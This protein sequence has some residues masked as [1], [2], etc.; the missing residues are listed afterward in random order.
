MKT[1]KPL[2]IAL[3]LTGIVTLNGCSTVG[4][5]IEKRN[6]SVQSKMSNS[7]FLEPVSNDKKTVY[8]QIRNSSDQSIDTQAMNQQLAK[9][10]QSKGYRAVNDPAQANYVLQQNILSVKETNKDDAYNS[11]DAGFGGATAGVLMAGSTG[12]NYAGGALL[13]AVAGIAADALVKDVYFNLVSDIQIKEKA[14]GK[15]NYTTQANAGSGTS[16]NTRQTISGQSDYL[17]HSTRIVAVANQVN[18]AFDEAK[19]MLEDKLVKSVAG[20][21]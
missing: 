4:T 10:L 19:P 5:A 20:I 21:F 7:V 12:N 17:T 9:T 11:M 13:G 6:L 8:I 2:I 16:M 15:V 14:K 1:M 3:S 18:L